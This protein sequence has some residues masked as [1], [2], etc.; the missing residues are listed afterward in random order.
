MSEFYSRNV[1]FARGETALLFVDLQRHVLRDLGVRALII[2]GFVTDQCVDMAVRDAAEK[3]Y[4]VTL[5]T[6]PPQP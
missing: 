4:L 3:G 5:S 2:S 6:T 1:P